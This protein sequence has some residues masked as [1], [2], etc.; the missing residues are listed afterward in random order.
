MEALGLRVTATPHA[1]SAPFDVLDGRLHRRW[2]LLPSAPRAVRVASLALIQPLR[3]RP[4]IFKWAAA[5]AVG[6]GGPHPWRR[7]SVHVSGVN[8]AAGVFGPTAAHAAFLTGTAGPHRKLTAQVMDDRGRI[9]G[10]VKVAR[11]PATRALL[12]N[13]ASRLVE[14][15]AMGLRTA[16]VPQLLLQDLSDDA[17]VLAMD[18]ARTQRSTC[19]ARLRPAHLAF[20]DELALRTASARIPDGDALLRRLRTQALGLPASLPGVWRQRFE[21][22]LDALA[23]AP[24]LIAPHG[25]AH[26]DFSPANT[27]WNGDRL[28]VFDWEYAGYDYPAGYD[29]IRFL[30]AVQTLRR[31]RIA[32]R[33]RAVAATLGQD[34]HWSPQTV[35]IRVLACLC[36]QALLLAGREPERAGQ[37]LSWEGEQATALTLD[38]LHAEPGSSLP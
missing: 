17:A 9:R 33:C 35:R 30:F 20:L 13:E 37:P 29:L 21:R 25:L 32:D 28:C 38:A 15:R 5:G 31:A 2:Y 36:A 18:T 7:A 8:L 26:G 19:R 3:T 24:A 4:R 34:L 10:Y 11:A 23:R 12:A 27:F 16:V 22:A 6:L 1:G 14:L